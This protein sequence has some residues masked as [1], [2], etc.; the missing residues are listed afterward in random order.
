MGAAEHFEICK[1]VES[2]P[3]GRGPDPS[4][5]AYPHH[6]GQSSGRECKKSPTSPHSPPCSLL[7]LPGNGM[8]SWK[9]L[10]R[11]E[12]AFGA[13]SPMGDAG[14]ISCLAF[15]GAEAASPPHGLALAAGQLWSEEQPARGWRAR[16]AKE[17]RRGSARLFISAIQKW[18]L[19]TEIESSFG[20]KFQHMMGMS[21]VLCSFVFFFKAW[22]SANWHIYMLAL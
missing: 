10:A 22:L 9:G 17:R 19:A 16:P 5:P 21:A 20:Q 1:S 14:P 13:S 6:A 7:F 4:Y 8:G 3:L 15:R 11:R 18:F 12:E 2:F